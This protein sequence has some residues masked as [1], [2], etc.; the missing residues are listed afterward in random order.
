[1]EELR[2]KQEHGDVDM[3]PCN[4][5]QS[6]MIAAHEVYDIIYVE[7]EAKLFN[8]KTGEKISRPKKEK[9]RIRV[10]EDMEKRGFFKGKTVKMLH[11]P[12]LDIEME[13]QNKKDN[14]SGETKTD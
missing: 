9:Y 13:Y 2:I 14:G 6:V 8:E 7:T 3:V 11:D 12:R 1:M 5:D 10:F 4:I